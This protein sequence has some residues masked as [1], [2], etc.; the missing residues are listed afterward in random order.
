MSDIETRL[1]RVLTEQAT[2]VERESHTPD[3]VFAGVERRRRRRSAMLAGTTV[4]ALVLVGASIAL[5]RDGS[6]RL[7]VATQPGGPV[8]TPTTASSPPGPGATRLATGTPIA[9]SAFVNGKLVDLSAVPVS[10]VGTFPATSAPHGAPIRTPFGLVAALGETNRAALW[11][12]S[13]RGEPL[14]KLAD[15]VA[16]FAVSADGRTVAWSEVQQSSP[17]DARSVLA[18]AS[19]PYGRRATSPTTV[20]GI[21]IVRG[22]TLG[23]VLLNT[24][25]GA[26]SRAAVWLP[27]MGRVVQAEG[28]LRSVA[29]TFPSGDRVVVNEGDGA[30]GAI[31]RVLGD[32]TLDVQAQP[33]L[34]GLAFSPAG[35]K[36]AAA[37]PSRSNEAVVLGGDGR[38]LLR[39]S[40]GGRILQG[41][42]L[43]N[44]RVAL[45]SRA[46]GDGYEVTTCDVKAQRCTPV[47]QTT[48]A[49]DPHGAATVWLLANP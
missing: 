10:Q 42:W 36:L 4:V 16:G 13:D 8:P 30:C 32:G 26:R 40:T 23:G 15:S 11:L 45:L 44:D 47:W 41:L 22:F 35:D 38:E 24:G 3:P 2:S 49:S 7:R 5:L 31:G 9:A 27:A 29:A 48:A 21:A 25:D 6:D 34:Q 46:S 37:D 43:G 12:L 17:S 28:D 1:R 18:T 33:C 20:T 14:T 39:S 19:L